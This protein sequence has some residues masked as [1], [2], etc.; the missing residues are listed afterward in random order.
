MRALYPLPQIL[1]LLTAAA[2]C[3]VDAA[4]L[5]DE[6]STSLSSGGNGTSNSG[7]SPDGPGTTAATSGGGGTQ[8]SPVALGY[9]QLCGMGCSP[10]TGSASACS[11]YDSSNNDGGGGA[12]GGAPT[13]T[14]IK[15]CYLVVEDSGDVQGLCTPAGTAPTGAPCLASTDCAPGHGCSAEGL[16][17]PYCC[18]EVEACPTNTFCA[19]RAV[20]KGDYR[21]AI[22]KAHVPFCVPASPCKL[23]DDST[24]NVNG[25][26]CTIVRNNG[27]TSCVTPGT[28]QHQDKCSAVSGP[29]SC[30]PGYTCSFA[31]GTC[32]KLCQTAAPDC[33]GNTKCLGGS[34]SFPK[35]F[36]VCVP[37][38]G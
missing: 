32:H 4:T 15:D 8:N 33:P 24:C 1:C 31:N 19:P 11:S 37:L 13:P 12:G 16:C 2:G 3:N 20:S 25:E 36:G 23:L 35:G 21:G 28:G 5:S 7:G 27:T 9:S 14:G 6:P 38:D 26:T 18:G 29:N 30:A 10:E 22:S 34:Y 17:Q